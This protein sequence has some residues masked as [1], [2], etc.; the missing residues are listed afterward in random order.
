MCFSIV[1]AFFCNDRFLFSTLFF[2][3]GVCEKRCH[4]I[5]TN[6]MRVEP[7]PLKVKVDACVRKAW[8]LQTWY[9]FSLSPCI[10]KRYAPTLTLRGKGLT[11]IGFC[12]KG[13]H[14]FSQTPVPKNRAEKRRQSLQKT[15]QRTHKLAQARPRTVLV[16]RNHRL[17]QTL[18]CITRSVLVFCHDEIFFGRLRPSRSL[19]QGPYRDRVQGPL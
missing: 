15:T 7:F 1:R 16:R 4:P 13:W 14:L 5:I 18:H 2:D 3:T 12:I 17:R 9:L 19:S 10:R 8:C 11:C 6:S